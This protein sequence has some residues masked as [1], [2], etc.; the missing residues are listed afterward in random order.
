MTGPGFAFEVR[1]QLLAG[2]GETLRARAADLAAVGAAVAA[3]RVEREWFG[4]LPAAGLLAERYAAHRDAELAE[5]GALAAWLA[6]AGAGLTD[7]AG[8]Y[9]GLGVG[10]EIPGTAAISGD[11]AGAGATADTGGEPSD[12]ALG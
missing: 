3:V 11:E 8:R 7:S 9:S 2:Y 10:I 4:R 12:G 1:P 6:E 5:A